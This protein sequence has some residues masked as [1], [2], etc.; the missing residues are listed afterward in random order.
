MASLAESGDAEFGSRAQKTLEQWTTWENAAARAVRKGQEARFDFIACRPYLQENF[1]KFVP[2]IFEKDS[3]GLARLQVLSGAG[4]FEYGGKYFYGFRFTIPRELDGDF[5][6]AFT[7]PQTEAT[8]KYAGGGGDFFILPRTGSMEGF[9]TF[10]RLNLSRFPR[11]QQQFPD[12]KEVIYQ[13]LPQSAL[14]P[15]D[16][17]AIWFA[18][19]AP[20]PPEIAFALSVDSEAGRHRFGRLPLE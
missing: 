3:T 1:S 13:T 11:L 20:N 8:R 5:E 14:R 10:R 18:F 15:G 17:Y 12:T 2:V 4:S 16:E 9:K 19:D 6:W 7:I